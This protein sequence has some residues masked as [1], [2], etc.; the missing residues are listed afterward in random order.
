MPSILFTERAAEAVLVPST[1]RSPLE[2]NVMDDD[3]PTFEKT[4]PKYEFSELV[5]MAIALGAWISG[6]RRRA[7]APRPDA[8]PAPTAGKELRAD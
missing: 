1:A 2:G 7:K 4:Y 8:P 3:P 5:R 6:I